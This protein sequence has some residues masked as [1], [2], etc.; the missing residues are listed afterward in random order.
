MFVRVDAAGN[1]ET[2]LAE[3]DLILDRTDQRLVPNHAHPDQ[4]VSE[5]K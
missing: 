5:G 1:G 2:V 3:I 4:P